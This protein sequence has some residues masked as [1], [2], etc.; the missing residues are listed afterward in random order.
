MARKPAAQ[1]LLTRNHI[2]EAAEALF[3]AKGLSRTT[4]QDI[5]VAAGVTRGAIYGH[6]KDK[7]Q[8]F[9][10]MMEHALHRLEAVLELPAAMP[11]DD[12]LEILRQHGYRLLEY[13]VMDPWFR[14]FVEIAAQKMEYVDELLPVGKGIV[15]ARE[16]HVVGIRGCLD[17]VAG[18]MANTTAL[19]IGFHALL[20][21]L[22]RNWVL[23]PSKFDLVETGRIAVDSYLRGLTND[24]RPGIAAKALKD[25]RKKRGAEAPL[26][27]QGR[28]QP[29]TV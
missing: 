10:A 4:L 20:D 18:P 22:L 29:L 21:G 27:S 24:A 12:P 28:N 11:G 23:D 17:R 16:R 6:F 7:S 13:P 9:D 5:A 3:A 26:S 14:R 2:L 15:R 8:L 19:A 1:A 25:R